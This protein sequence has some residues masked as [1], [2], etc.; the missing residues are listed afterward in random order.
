MED[1]V[2][3]ACTAQEA[4]EVGSLLRACGFHH[5]DESS[6]CGENYYTEY[7][8]NTVRDGRCTIQV[9]PRCKR[10]RGLGAAGPPVDVHATSVEDFKR[11]LH[12]NSD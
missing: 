10:Y 12:P 5:G 4:L 3:V 7:Y 8:K 1:S 6:V 9:F 2:Y 11:M